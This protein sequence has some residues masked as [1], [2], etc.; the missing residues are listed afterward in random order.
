MK[1]PS[2]SMGWK[3]VVA[4]GLGHPVEV[5]VDVSVAPVG[6][7]LAVFRPGHQVLFAEGFG[8]GLLLGFLAALQLPVVVFRSVDDVR[9]ALFVVCGSDDGRAPRLGVSVG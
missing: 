1:Q 3:I 7:V 6:E 4:P 5:G 2:F 9:E 8:L